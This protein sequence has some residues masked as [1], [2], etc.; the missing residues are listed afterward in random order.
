MA[1][2]SVVNARGV[3]LAAMSLRNF[4]H[5]PNSGIG[6]KS[7]D[8]WGEFSNIFRSGDQPLPQPWNEIFGPL[9]RGRDDEIVGHSG[10]GRVYELMV[11]GQIRQSL[12]GRI[13]TE[14]GH[15]KYINGPAGLT[16]LHRLRA[17][18]DAVVIGVGTAIADDPHLTV[19]GAAGP[20][21]AR[22]VIDPNGR[23]DSKAKVFSAD[24][25]RRILV[26]TEGKSA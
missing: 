14:S 16:H 4:P 10:R 1:P 7:S 3:L 24:G 15:S 20:Q 17:L 8:P 25:V 9:R 22:V 13:A 21:P 5:N 6:G 23:L 2:V 26:T 11:V 19:Q 12:D 18:V